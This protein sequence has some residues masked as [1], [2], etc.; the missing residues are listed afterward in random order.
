MPQ[1]LIKVKKYQGVYFLESR[2]TRFQG[3]SDKCYYITYR[4]TAGK[5]K[6]EKVGRA[7][8]G[9]NAQMAVHVR[10]ERMR[11]IR[12]GDEIPNKNDKIEFTFGEAW[13]KYNKWLNTGKKHPESD[14]SR[15]KNHI[16]KRFSKKYLSE[17]TP[18]EIEKFRSLLIKQDLAPA[19]VKHILI[20][21]RQI[22]N[23]M[24]DW[25]LW[26]GD[27]PL[28]GV[29]I[30]KLKNKVERF[31]THGEAH[32]LLTKLNDV[33]K[34]LHDMSQIS[35]HTGMRAVEVL[36]IRWGHLDF[37]NRIIHVAD[38]KG[39][40]SE[41]RKA[42]MTKSVYEILKSM[43]ESGP[44]KLVFEARGGGKMKTISKAYYRAVKDLGFNDGIEDRR[45]RVTFHTLRHT[46]ASWLA[47]QG[48]PIIEIKELLGHE[49]L[50]MTERYAHLTPDQKRFAVEKLEKSFIENRPS[51]PE[52]VD[53][54]SPSP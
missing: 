42:F 23:K 50:E 20:L 10:G 36:G 48:T 51:G 18:Y 38:T 26:E 53:T 5:F 8:E 43:E 17:I 27:H 9:Y 31:L 34:Q 2:K 22:Y 1:D 6:R 15:Y 47:I 3:K 52:N 13:E 45:Q 46:F 24:K 28:K 39:E 32:T 14:R 35:L 30:P 37:E 33:S 11:K 40:E 4:N 49:T 21:I 44:E 54:T 16:K 19:T 7:S 25:K 41:P 12:H 29:K